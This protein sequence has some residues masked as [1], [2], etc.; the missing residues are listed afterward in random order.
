MS[1]TIEIQLDTFS[2]GLGALGGF[3]ATLWSTA[4]LFLGTKAAILTQ[5]QP[6]LIVIGLALGAVS[7]GYSVG[8]NEDT[9]LNKTSLYSG[10]AAFLIIGFVGLT[11]TPLASAL[12]G[13]ESQQELTGDN[14]RT[15]TIKVEGMVCQG[16]KRTVKNYLKS[17]DGTKRVDI[18]LSEKKAEV[19]YD[20]DKTS[21][22]E[23][24]NAKVFQ[25][26]YSATLEEDRR[27]QS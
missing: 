21:A 6:L 19:I 24:V 13:L 15:A 20:S 4:P 16:C 9:F 22:E 11:V 3:I 2:I 14:L 1:E 17:M 25:G 23:L 10:L 12:V 26:A 5:N 18:T 27:Y 7:A 8:I